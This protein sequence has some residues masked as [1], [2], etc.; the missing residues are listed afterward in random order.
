MVK[1][2]GI[3]IG[4][5]LG[6][7]IGIGGVC[8]CAYALLLPIHVKKLNFISGCVNS[9]NISLKSNPPPLRSPSPLVFVERGGL[10]G[11]RPLGV[12][13]VR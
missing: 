2:T 9:N 12:V 7:G 10:R 3:G 4:A 8:V 5:H 1:Y 13:T 6:I 11:G